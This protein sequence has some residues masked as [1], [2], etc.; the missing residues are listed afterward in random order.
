M[1]AG[2]EETRGVRRRGLKGSL[3]EPEGVAEGAGS[4]VSEGAGRDL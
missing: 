4:G 1:L 2:C 3:K